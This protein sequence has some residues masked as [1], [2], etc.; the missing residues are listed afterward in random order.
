DL[1]ARQQVGRHQSDRAADDVTQIAGE[2]P[3]VGLAEILQQYQ[4]PDECGAADEHVVHRSSCSSSRC[5]DRLCCSL[6]ACRPPVA[7]AATAR[8]SA[9]SAAGALES[10]RAQ[11]PLLSR[12][13][14][15]KARSTIGSWPSWKMKI[16][17]PSRPSSSAFCASASTLSSSASP[18]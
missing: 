10:K 18:T 7:Y 12:A 2:L 6:R 3:E 15:R 4:Q 16:G 5:A 13:N 14:S 11:A 8:S 9:A 1:P 17:Q